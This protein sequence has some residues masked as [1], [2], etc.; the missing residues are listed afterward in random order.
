MNDD[1]AMGLTMAHLTETQNKMLLRLDQ[2]AI[3]ESEPYFEK[4]RATFEQLA[5][6]GL[7]ERVEVDDGEYTW[8]RVEA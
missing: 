8:Q 5:A 7:A 6:K 3:A 2:R 1:E 4:A